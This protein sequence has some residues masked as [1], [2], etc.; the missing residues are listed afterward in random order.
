MSTHNLRAPGSDKPLWWRV[1]SRKDVIAGLFFMAIAVLGLWVSRNYPIGTALRMSTGYVPRLLCWILLLIGAGLYLT[2][3]N[4]Q[5]TQ[6]SPDSA[7]VPDLDPDASTQEAKESDPPEGIRIPGYPSITIP[8]DTKEVT[9]NLMNPEGNPC[10]FTFTLVLKD[11]D[12]TIYQSK[13]VEPG[14]AITQITLSKELSAGEYPAILKIST[15]ALDDGRAMN[16][17]NVETVLKVQ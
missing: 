16:G 17:A 3:N 12:E 14:K 9:V 5:E 7:F 11:T 15:A 4:K 2:R 1:L 8:A 10:Y 13:M 6:E